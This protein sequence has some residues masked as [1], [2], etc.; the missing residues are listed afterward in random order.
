M[1]VYEDLKEMLCRELEEITRKGELT[2]GSLDTVDKLTHSI[3]SI[4]TIIA[5]NEYGDNY[6]FADGGMSNARG[7]N[8]GGGRSYH[9]DGGYSYAGRGR[10]ARRD[11]M[12]RYSRDGGYSYADAKE[13]MMEELRELMHDAPDEQVKKEFQRFVNKLESM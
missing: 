1:H 6:S 9:G 13:D 5:M 12:G 7:G 10:N 8:R 3:K 2:A 11:S 4:E